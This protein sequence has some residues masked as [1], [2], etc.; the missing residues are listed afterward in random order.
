MGKL[1]QP[2]NIILLCICLAFIP[3]PSLRGQNADQSANKHMAAHHYS[4][5]C[6]GNEMPSSAILTYP[7]NEFRVQDYNF[8][9]K[10]MPCLE[11]DGRTIYPSEFESMV[12]EDYPGGVQATVNHLG[13]RMVTR[14]TPLLTGRGS[15]IWNGAVMYEVE[16]VPATQV[17]VFLGGGE[18]IN[19]IWGFETSVMKQDAV[20]RLKN[21]VLQNSSTL[22]FLGGKENL[23]V[24][25]KASGSLSLQGNEASPVAFASFSEGRGTILTGFSEKAADLSRIMEFDGLAETEKVHNYYDHLL[26]SSMETPEGVMNDAFASAICNLEYS[27]LEPF[28]WGECLHHWLALW[29]MQVTPAAEWIGQHDRSRSS[30]LAHGLAPFENGAIPMFNPNHQKM[31]MKRRD[32]GGANTYWVWQV[33]HYLKQTGDLEFAR[34]VVPMV[35]RA[36]E[37]T[38][39]EYDPDG[40]L[41]IAWGL[42]IGNQEDFVANPYDGSVPTMELF[43][44]FVTRAELSGFTGDLQ[45]SN[46]WYQRA[47]EIRQ[48]LYKELWIKDLGRFAYYRDPTNRILP[49]GPYQ[50]Y[51]YPAIYGLVDL[52]DQYSGLR[53]LL[54]RLTDREGAVFASNNFAW[55]VPESVSTWG[56]QRGAAQQPWAAMGFSASGL[57][58]LTWKP[59]KAMA[60]WAQDPRRPGSWPETGPEPTPAYFTPPAGLYIS[61]VVEALFGLKPNVPENYLELSPSFPDH[62]PGAK[63]NLPGLSADY[64]RKKN[65]LQ[66][67]L[68]SSMGLPLRVKWRIPVSRINRIKVNNKEVEYKVLPGVNHV[69]VSFDVAAS[70]KTVILMDLD[71]VEY[72]VNAPNSI[73]AGETLYIALEGAVIEK[74]T[75]K[76]GILESS[77]ITSTSSL[78]GLVQ[79]GLLDPYSNYKKLGQL[80]FSRRTLFLDCKT[81]DGVQFIVPVDLT[82]L[83]RMEAAM[84]DSLVYRK[85]GI[86]LS[87]LLRNNT[88]SAIKGESRL[89]VGRHSI[90]LQMELEPRSEQSIEVALPVGVSLAAG[91][92]IATL[93]YP[94][95]L[96][97]SLSFQVKTP[98]VT[99]VFVPVRL[100]VDAMVPDTTWNDLRVM[101]GF[102]H[103]FFTFSTYGW[104]K[105]ME[106]F[107]DLAEL[108]VAEIPGLKFELSGRHFIPLSHLSGKT[109]WELTLEKKK[110][111]KLYLLVLPFVDNHDMFSEVARITA[112]SGT[113]AVYSRTLSYPGDLDY[114]VSN[115]NPTSFAS[116]REVRDNPYEL[117][118]MLNPE[119]KDLA[120]GKPPDFPQSRWWS[121]SLPLATES[122]VMSVVEISLNSPMELE[123]LVFETL[124]AMPAFGIVAVTAELSE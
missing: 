56:M 96:P 33:R 91:E 124:G 98:P 62:W 55:H 11:K 101:P 87:M 52:Y 60:E 119:K 53:H 66:Y 4:V 113:K 40:N 123:S 32:W 43:N 100:P 106:A 48:V 39:E 57:N 89:L 78:T 117:L 26:L 31:G 83:P 64:S 9:L 7:V 79:S 13:T 97:L 2:V 28:G 22:S 94:G 122:C 95:E 77:R 107:K 104:P 15:E 93:S 111:K 81:P 8:L 6:T 34:Q 69:I 103:I 46:Q 38:L 45:A 29:Y 41:L 44:M 109:S 118:P 30:I 17:K 25:V 72:Q 116:Y 5:V 49:D 47:E 120:E 84:E 51:L 65:Q 12:V 82:I 102:P 88:E 105:P 68:E 58:N 70:Q 86:G 36:I 21:A 75:D 114:W 50:T 1:N 37:Q 76:C 42:Q 27:W 16:T 108:T 23:L 54:D 18:T 90:P 35:D 92:N 73:A 3:A 110:Y 10:L 85:D 19:L 112:Y 63:L 115:R 121:T 59:L 74:I 24:G 67:T 14:I 71:P 20:G 99:P 61:T 80:N